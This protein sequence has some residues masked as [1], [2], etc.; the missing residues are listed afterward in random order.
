MTNNSSPKAGLGNLNVLIGQA[1]IEKEQDAYWENLI[2]LFTKD[3]HKNFIRARSIILDFHLAFDF[4]LSRAILQLCVS[5]AY[6]IKLSVLEEKELSR[7]SESLSKIE[8]GKRM[9]V[10]FNLGI[11]SPDSQTIISKVNELRNGFAHIKKVNDAT[12]NYKG[13]SIFELEGISEIIK[14][15]DKVHNEFFNF[16]GIKP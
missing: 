9:Q 7:L 2:K 11:F 16:M 12:F 14:D 13:K 5:G 6:L 10:V 15:Y 4:F 1:F 8:F 3:K